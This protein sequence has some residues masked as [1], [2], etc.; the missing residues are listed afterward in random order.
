MRNPT[1]DTH[2]TVNVPPNG[3]PR[4][5]DIAG[6]IHLSFTLTPK[7]LGNDCELAIGIMRVTAKSRDVSLVARRDHTLVADPD[8]FNETL[9]YNTGDG[10]HFHTIRSMKHGTMVVVTDTTRKGTGDIVAVY[11]RKSFG[12]YAIDVMTWADSGEDEIIDPA[13]FFETGRA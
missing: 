10:C 5:F 4:H 13:A 6:K 11:V 3:I 9:F 1:P 8:R 2:D 12:N 7:G